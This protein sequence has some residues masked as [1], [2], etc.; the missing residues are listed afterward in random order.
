MNRYCSRTARTVVLSSAL[1]PSVDVKDVKGGSAPL[2]L[3]GDSV[4]AL[5]RGHD[6]ATS[7]ADLADGLVVLVGCAASR[8]EVPSAIGRC[9]THGI[10]VDAP[11][12]T[13]LV[14]LLKGALGE[15]AHS[16][17]EVIQP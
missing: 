10:Q 17:G 13:E 14:T 12:R 4:P 16:L 7:A 3:G 9:F 8:E 11:G 15:A 1:T 2:A 5:S 6:Q